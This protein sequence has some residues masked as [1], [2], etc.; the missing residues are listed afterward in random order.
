[1]SRAGRPRSIQVFLQILVML[2]LSGCTTTAQTS[3]P[4]KKEE[5]CDLL[6]SFY[7][8]G[9]GINDKAVE[10]LGEYLAQYKKDKISIDT[11]PWGREGEVDY[12]LKFK[13][14]TPEKKRSLIKGIRENLNKA[15]HVRLEENKDSIHRRP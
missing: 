7:S 6:I 2:A 11:L 4:S 5:V 14:L 12:C 9:G 13:D 10:S 3:A 15:E 8:I 1:M